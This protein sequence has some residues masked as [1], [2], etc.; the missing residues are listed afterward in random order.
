MSNPVYQRELVG[1]LR[2]PK[3]LAVQIL[4]AL[5]CSLL[6]LLRWPTD[7]QVE[8]SG[9]HSQQVF[10][11]FAYGLLAAIILLVPVFPATSIV[12][13]RMRRTLELL[14][15][16]PLR[17][18]SIYVGKL[19]AV[20]AFVLLL[21]LIS[22]PAAAACYVMGGV[23]LG[24]QLLLLYGLLLLV[25]VQYAALGL[26]V[27]SFASST[28]SALRVTYGLVLV[29][30]VISLGPHLFLQGQPGWMAE[31]AG[32]LRCLSPVPAV[33]QLVGHA[34]IGGQGLMTRVDVTGRFVLLA[35]VTTLLFAG[36]TILRLNQTML[37][38][39]R[40]QGVITEDRGLGGRLLRRMF[41][42]VDPQRRSR[43]I[44]LLTNAVMIKEFRSRRFGRSHWMMRLI[45]LCVLVSLG[46]TYASSMGTMQWGV[47]TIGGIMV[48]LQVALIVLLTPSLAAGLI[49]G[50]RESGSWVLLQ[51]TPLSAGKII[52]GKLLSVCWTLVLIL[53]ATLPGYVVM[54]F[55]QPQMRF[56]V[57]R[58]LI[59]LGITAVFA[60]LL[61]AAIGSLF[62][63]A[64][65]ATTAAYVALVII[66]AGPMLIWLGR[67]AP[68]GHTAVETALVIN[69]LAAALQVIEMP[70]FREYNL[71]PTNWWIMGGASL[72]LLVG[73][74]VQTWS[75]RR[76]S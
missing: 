57:E 45:A 58:V 10:R 63:R 70:G 19:V 39:A 26:L 48:L 62:R 64:A 72:A 7:A 33:M 41:F 44:S 28:D 61:S 16:S 12:H 18:W 30:A 50:E 76:P 6:I 27:S 5:G 59:S 69:P 24:E 43:G 68:F 40:D 42:L 3:A 21:L 46:L 52:R 15:N 71:V 55:I 36:R 67:N 35:V 51:M 38:R 9:T 11:L 37:D 53:L 25:A 47:E 34:D 60:M 14:L 49:S 66:C 74:S 54:V 2:T 73:L 56:Q 17:P 32:W 65:A 13:E 1:L 75:L 31:L 4:V 29:M 20:L 8:L 23:A 22:L